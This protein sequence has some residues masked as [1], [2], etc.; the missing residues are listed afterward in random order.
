MMLSYRYHVTAW[1]AGSLM[2]AG[3]AIF[4]FMALFLMHSEADAG[5]HDLLYLALSITDRLPQDE[6]AAADPA[7]FAMVGDYVRFTDRQERIA[8]SIYTREGRLLHAT[9]GAPRLQ[10]LPAPPT[11]KIYSYTW[12]PRGI[13]EWSYGLR[14]RSENWEVLLRSSGH[15]ET[16]EQLLTALSVYL[17]LVASMSLLIGLWVS[18]RVVA[19]LAQIA[20][21]AQ[22][23]SKGH[24]DARIGAESMPHV[25][26][27]QLADQLDASFEQLEQLFGRVSEF[28][29]NVAHELRTPLTV[30]RGN[31][32][33][34]LRQER[35]VVDYQ[36]ALA[37]GIEAI[38]HLQHL[39]ES[40]LLLSQPTSRL[41]ERFEKVDLAARIAMVVDQVEFLA[42]EAGITLA[43]QT[44]DDV[45]VQG[46][47]TLLTRMIY[48]PIHNAIKYAPAG[49]TVLVTLETHEDQAVLRVRD[50]G[51]GVPAEHLARIFDRFYQVDRSR[52]AGTG[53]GLSIAQWIVTAHRGHIEAASEAGRGTT[54]TIT[55][56][57]A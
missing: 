26:L 37:S 30:L 7:V 19:P 10:D 11:G 3:L 12:R 32:E 47:P 35:D 31:L 8:F 36:E 20:R 24:L 21:T 57:L 38:A 29:A 51:E 25:E 49:S 15:E 44:Q 43:I 46:V 55:L 28:S 33:V 18:R 39:V 23:L 17:L 9:D 1:I 16:L 45:H 50:E 52:T 34:G 40:L 4:L 27:Q 54:I 48:N 2:L 13:E 56:P 14:L 53:L 5:R 41:A 6:E 22:Q 42:D